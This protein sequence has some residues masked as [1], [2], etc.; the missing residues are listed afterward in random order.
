MDED[1]YWSVSQARPQLAGAETISARVL[2]VELRKPTTTGGLRHWWDR[3][4]RAD[5]TPTG[6]DLGAIDTQ[7]D[8][9]DRKDP[10]AQREAMRAAWDEAHRL[11][12]E[13]RAQ[14]AAA[15]NDE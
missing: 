6:A 14:A 15:R 9:V 4:L 3:L 11:F 10:L 5:M 1:A 8:V 7:A 12:R 13:K 2:F